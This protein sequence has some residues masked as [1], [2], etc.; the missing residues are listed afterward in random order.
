LTVSADVTDADVGQL[1]LV[2]STSSAKM[3]S[4]GYQTTSNYG[5]ISALIAG[6]GYSN[7]ALQPNGG[8]VGIGTTTPF[9]TAANRTVLSVNGTTD[10]SLNIGSGGSQRAYLYGASSYAELGTIGSLPLT[11]APNNSE[12]M[13]ITVVG[14]VGIGT[15]SP[16]TLLHVNGSTTAGGNILFTSEYYS[17]SFPTSLTYAGGVTGDDGNYKR[18]CLYHGYAINFII[19][20]SATFANSKMLLDSTGNLGIGTTS[21]SVKLHVDGFFISKT[22]WS[23]V[24]AHS[25]WG[26]YSTAYGRLTWDTGLAWINATAGNVL[27]LGADGANKHVTI[28]TSGNVGIGT[29]SPSQKLEVS[30]TILASAFSGPLTGN[31]TGNVTGSSG[32]CTGNAASAGALNTSNDYTVA[33]LTSNGFVYSGS[34]AGS[35]GAFYFNSS[36]HGI[37][38]ASG[39]ND[40]YCYTTTGTL[41]LG[42]DGSSTTHI[43]VLSGGDVGIGVSP[44][45][46]LDV[47]GNIHA[48]GF[49]TSSDIRFKKNITPLEN[50]LEK[51]KK[52][53]GVKYEWNEFVNSVR[54]GY[55]LNVPIIGLI[56][57]DVEKIVPEVVDLWKLSDDCQDARSIDYPRLTPLL[58]EAIKEQQIIIENQNQKIENLIARMSALEAK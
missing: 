8:N 29:A 17:L 46:K 24:A 1:R 2:G 55:K 19:G 30:G 28:A 11:F 49:P 57:Q 40:V 43:R 52:L 38:R 50:S 20:N 54:D 23:D 34:S 10:V 53:Q 33:S 22:L 4:L 36:S 27:Y 32:S 44:S 26:N 31:V 3:L 12:K 45:Y 48:T 35:T 41:Y 6:T 25:Y 7:L 15:T 9:G 42:A 51:I 58:I 13:R 56:A 39:T 37:R 18:L 5:F 16:S 47:N 14:N 21:P